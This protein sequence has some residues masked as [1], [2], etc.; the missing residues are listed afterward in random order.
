MFGIGDNVRN[1]LKMS[2]EQ[3]KL[4]LMS[5]GEDLGEVNVKRDISRDC[6]SPILFVLSMVPVTI[7][8]VYSP[9]NTAEDKT[10][11]AFYECLKRA[12]ESVPAHNVLILLGDFNARIGTS[13]ARFPYHMI[14]NRNGTHLVDLMMEKNL[15]VTN[16]SFQKREGK[17][18][19]YMDPWG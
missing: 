18:W 19:T 2:M 3:W 13:D 9:T 11:E 6:L 1:L 14:T 8:T 12:I 17:L 15:V 10:I 7:I 16:T 4:S 5:N